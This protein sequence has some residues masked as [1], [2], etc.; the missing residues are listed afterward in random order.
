MLVLQG[1]PNQC[2]TIREISIYR[3]IPMVTLYENVKP[4][5]AASGKV[6]LASGIAR[7]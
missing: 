6:G 2:P 5:D 7:R 3:G 4:S 1:T